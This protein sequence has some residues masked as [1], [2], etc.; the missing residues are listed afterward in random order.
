[1]AKTSLVGGFDFGWPLLSLRSRPLISFSL[2][3][4]GAAS[5]VNPVRMSYDELP[6]LLPP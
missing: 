4:E 5:A 1:M 2:L 3:F 6:F